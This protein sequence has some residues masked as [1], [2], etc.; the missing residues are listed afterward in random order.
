MKLELMLSV[1]D[2]RGFKKKKKEK[3]LVL[4]LTFTW[5]FGND[6]KFDGLSEVFE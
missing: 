3:N 2:I 5:K 4:W 1:G 6:L